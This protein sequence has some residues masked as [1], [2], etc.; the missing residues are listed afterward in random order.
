VRFPFCWLFPNL[1]HQNVALRTAFLDDAVREEIQNSNS[2]EIKVIVLGAGFDTRALRFMQYENSSSYEMSWHEIDLPAVVEQKSSL[3]RRYRQRRLTQQIRLPQLIGADM[4]DPVAVSMHLT[5]LFE[6]CQDTYKLTGVK[7][8]KKNISKCKTIF[9]IEAVL[10]YLN[11]DIIPTLLDVCV[12]SASKYSS[13]VSICFAD[14]LP[15]L[16]VNDKDSS[17]EYT[18]A[19][20]L[21]KQISMKL[22]KWLPKPGRARHMGI[23]KYCV[24]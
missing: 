12:K 19:A 8:L 4:N 22:T 16:P 2:S 3:L 18:A 20:N 11:Q 24:E 6:T 23:A 21:F 7:M 9:V 1:H 15:G 10:M 13:A 14:R 17:N 5:E